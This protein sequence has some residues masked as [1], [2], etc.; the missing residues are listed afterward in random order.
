MRRSIRANLFMSIFAIFLAGLEAE[1]Q[2]DAELTLLGGAGDLG[3][4]VQVA[5][6]A[7]G[8]ELQVA[9]I[10]TGIA[11]LGSV[12]EIERLQTKLQIHFLGHRKV[13]EQ[14]EVPVCPA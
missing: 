7:V 1:P 10:R 3:K 2:P 5:N 14:A 8:I 13:P 11:E 4:T 12:G 6:R 9:H